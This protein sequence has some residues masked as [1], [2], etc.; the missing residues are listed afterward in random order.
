MGINSQ[1]L[2]ARCQYASIYR[3]W[4]IPPSAVGEEM[5]V[6]DDG[7]PTLSTE[8]GPGTRKVRRVLFFS[9]F[10]FKLHLL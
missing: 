10:K 2:F 9:Y 3:D 1:W 8:V 5:A 4:F 6:V 7:I